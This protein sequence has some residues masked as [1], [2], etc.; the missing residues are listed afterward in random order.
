MVDV[1][2]AQALSSP[3]WDQFCDFEK[4]LPQKLAKLISDLTHKAAIYHYQQLP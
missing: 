1:V 2:K 3:S 4:I